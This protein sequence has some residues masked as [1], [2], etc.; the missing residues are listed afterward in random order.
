[1]NISKYERSN[2]QGIDQSLEISLLEYGL[3]WKQYKRSTK[4]KGRKGEYLFIYPV[5]STDHYGNEII[6]TD[7]G[8]IMP[9]NLRVEFDWIEWNS[10]YSYTGLSEIEFHDQDFGYQVFNL[11]QYYGT[12]EIFGS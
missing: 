11:V 9:C 1:M 6:I 3:I 7:Y 8:Y 5:Y 12:L 4:N 2:F 10:I